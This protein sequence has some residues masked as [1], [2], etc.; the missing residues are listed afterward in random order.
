M[1]GNYF[2]SAMHLLSNTKHLCENMGKLVMN[3]LLSK[4]DLS[5]VK[6]TDTGDGIASADTF[7]HV[8]AIMILAHLWTTVGVFRWVLDRIMSIRS[9][10][11]GTVVIYF[12][13]Y[14]PPAAP[15]E[16]MFG[17]FRTRE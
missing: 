17:L 13:L 12:Q 9:L 3:V 6:G 1:S 7:S 8:C 15:A 16:V 4:L 14:P 2:V 5:H 10:D 11:S